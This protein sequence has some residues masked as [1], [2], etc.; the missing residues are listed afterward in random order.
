MSETL[1]LCECIWLLLKPRLPFKDSVACVAVRAFA[2]LERSSADI[3]DENTLHTCH[4][5]PTPAKYER[6]RRRGRMYN[7]P[8]CILS[9]PSFI[10]CFGGYLDGLQWIPLCI[11]L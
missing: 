4:V 6:C 1:A 5:E 2:G 3:S 7:D 9:T 11:L 10:F 8:C